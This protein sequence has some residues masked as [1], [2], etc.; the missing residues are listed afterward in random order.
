MK[1]RKITVKGIRAVATQR[2]LELNGFKILSWTVKAGRMVVIE[3][4]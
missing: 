4:K 2:I 3:Y 1:A